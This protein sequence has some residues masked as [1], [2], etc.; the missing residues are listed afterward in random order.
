MII[1]FTN[2]ITE[3]KVQQMI[4]D[5]MDFTTG[6]INLTN[7]TAEQVKTAFTDPDRWLCTITYSGST[8]MEQYRTATTS[9]AVIYFYVPRANGR[10]GA[11]IYDGLLHATVDSA[12][13]EVTTNLST[14]QYAPDTIYDLDRM[15]Q[16]QINALITRIFYANSGSVYYRNVGRFTVRWTYNNKQYVYSVGRGYQLPDGESLIG[17]S[18]VIE[19]TIPV[20]YYDIA[21]LTT[22]GITHNEYVSN[23]AFTPVQ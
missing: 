12:T 18:M 23:I 13:G 7:A 20:I 11:N 22:N 6:V 4:N 3:A 16:A 9:G 14:G 5:A 10:S 17:T 8:Y 19:N 2:R 1:D 15:N 21:V